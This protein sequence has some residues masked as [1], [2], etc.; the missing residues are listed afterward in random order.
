MSGVKGSGSLEGAAAAQEF[1]RPERASSV[2]D[3][4][5]EIPQVQQ[6]PASVISQTLHQWRLAFP[7]IPH[8]VASPETV[9]VSGRALFDGAKAASAAVLGACTSQ[10]S[11]QLGG[12]TI[13]HN[14]AR[15]STDDK[16]EGIKAGE[17]P[18]DIGELEE[19]ES[20]AV[21]TPG[22]DRPLAKDEGLGLDRTRKAGVFSETRTIVD[23]KEATFT[24]E[25]LETREKTEK[26]VKEDIERLTSRK[27]N[28][29]AKFD[30]A[31]KG[32]DAAQKKFDAAQKGFDAAQKGFDAARAL[33]IKEEAGKLSREIKEEAGKLSREIDDV[34]HRLQSCHQMLKTLDRES[35]CVHS[36]F[37]RRAFVGKGPDGS[38]NISMRAVGEVPDMAIKR[39]EFD[40]HTRTILGFGAIGDQRNTATSLKELKQ[41]VQER[42]YERLQE[43]RKTLLER[44]K[45]LS[46]Q[47]RD[48]VQGVSKLSDEQKAQ[49]KAEITQLDGQV[50]ALDQKLTGIK[51][52]IEE[53]GGKVGQA[54]A[55]LG[56]RKKELR[57]ELQS[58]EAKIKELKLKGSEKPKEK[59]KLEKLENRKAALEYMIKDLQNPERALAQR[60]QILQTQMLSVVS[61]HVKLRAKEGGIGG[62]IDIAHVALLHPDK[63]SVDKGSGLEHDE[64]HLIE[65]GEQIFEEFNGKTIVFDAVGTVAYIDPDDGNKIHLPAPE[66]S[67]VG[68]SIPLHT[69]F[70][71]TTVVSRK[72]IS[73]DGTQMMSAMNGKVIEDVQK[74]LKARIVGLEKKIETAEVAERKQLS[75]ELSKLKASHKAVNKA[76]EAMKI[77]KFSFSHATALIEAQRRLGWSVSTG[78][79]SNKDRGGHTS[80]QSLLEEEIHEREAMIQEEAKDE[81][82]GEQKKIIRGLENEI[83]G[84]LRSD[85]VEMQLVNW[86]ISGMQHTLKVMLEFKRFK[87]PFKALV[88]LGK[89][90]R[91]KSVTE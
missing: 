64:W 27:E 24:V 70:T 61:S 36:Q 46:G 25:V 53:R 63:E 77:G 75:I 45:Y 2:S 31:Q 29:Q 89:M 11:A 80:K 28:L 68:K 78:C 44:G 79:Y 71:N 13:D 23:G 14:Q 85:S 73:E 60:T 67:L 38:K 62:S 26:T 34:E 91:D 21:L 87:N 90:L 19:K 16:V 74:Q 18:G 22:K 66:G 20:S 82:K 84:S 54:T 35:E 49:I 40:G 55:K 59:A 9:T 37:C 69:H 58:I 4:F 3:A 10:G 42:E 33:K 30:A 51:K 76:A 81:T 5:R 17:V 15:S 86:T 7:P 43:E 39:M 52:S 47:L 50:R 8:G 56:E 12:H 83:G 72:A 6:R 48:D 32:F 1:Q 65:D 57:T 41:V 88:Q